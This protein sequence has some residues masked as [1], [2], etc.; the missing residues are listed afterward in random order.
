MDAQDVGTIALD[1]L[2]WGDHVAPALGHSLSIGGMQDSL[3]AQPREWL[4]K[5]DQ[6]SIGQDLGPESGVQQVH[7]GML[8]AA[9]V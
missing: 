8:G 4:A 9:H 5:V 1:N 2:I 6:P 7:H 3:A